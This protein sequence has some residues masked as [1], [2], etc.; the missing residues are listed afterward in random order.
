DRQIHCFLHH[1]Q[2][3]Q[4]CHYRSNNYYQYCRCYIYLQRHNLLPGGQQSWTTIYRHIQRRGV[5]RKLA[6]P[7]DQ[8]DYRRN[9]SR[10]E[11]A[12]VTITF[13]NRP[14]A[15]VTTTDT[16]CVGSAATLTAFA[17][18]ATSYRWYD[19]SAGGTV[20]HTG[21][22]YTTDALTTAGVSKFYVE[23]L[24]NGVSG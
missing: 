8:S 22:N 6:G 9:K 1:Q 7:C 15:P 16:V 13:I 12:R 3:M 5:Y 4:H 18:G 20:L 10:R 23:A 17:P 14:A 2:R 21:A 24:I 19:A 11:T